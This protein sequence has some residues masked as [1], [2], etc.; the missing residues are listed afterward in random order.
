MNN[1]NMQFQ[2][3]LFILASH[4]DSKAQDFLTTYTASQ[5][6]GP[7]QLICFTNSQRFI[8]ISGTDTPYSILNLLV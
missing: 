6:T 5:K 2:V 3:P 1:N 7:P 8:L 4:T